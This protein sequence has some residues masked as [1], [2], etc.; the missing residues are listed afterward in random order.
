MTAWKAQQQ[1]QSQAVQAKTLTENAQAV[2]RCSDVP[3]LLII[4]STSRH[5][6][7]FVRWLSCRRKNA[8]T[9]EVL[10]YFFPV[11]IVLFHSV[12]SQKL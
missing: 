8:L 10:F 1:N 11:V 5:P 3:A 7:M 4:T 2:S 12:A 9:G 6:R